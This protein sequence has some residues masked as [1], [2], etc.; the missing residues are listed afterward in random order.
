MSIASLQKM[1]TDE[2]AG[3]AGMP[4][5]KWQVW[6]G[7]VLTG[8]TVLFMLFDAAGKFMVPAFVVQSCARLGFPVNLSPTLGVLLTVST[9]L[10]A[11]PRTAVLGAVLL[12]G[13]MGG[14]AA[15]HLRAGST[16]F[17]MLFPVLFG[18]VFWAGIYLR[19]SR[20]RQVFPIR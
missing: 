19:D 11:I 12:T 17:E 14:A 10:Y 6:T 4:T 2:S 9:L 15:I 16:L 5:A 7:R 13:Y 1:A 18:I 8:I 3:G 20:L